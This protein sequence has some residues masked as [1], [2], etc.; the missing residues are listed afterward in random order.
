MLKKSLL[1]ISMIGLAACSGTA[2]PKQ[3]YGVKGGI[4]GAAVGAGTGAIIGA[5]IANGDVAASALLGGG[6]GLAVGIAAGVAY[7]DYLEDQEVAE[8]NSAIE[9]RRNTILSNQQEIDKLRLET[10]IESRTVNI[11]PDNSKYIYDGPSL[12]NHYRP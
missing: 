4:G 11:D 12:G 5:A 6:I 9:E 2:K 3:E 8:G 10:D 1:L 7:A